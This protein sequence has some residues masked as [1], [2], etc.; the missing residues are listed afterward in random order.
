MFATD[1]REIL[2]AYSIELSGLEEDLSRLGIRIYIT[3][4][5]H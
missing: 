1:G 3:L 2:D 5:H 4:S